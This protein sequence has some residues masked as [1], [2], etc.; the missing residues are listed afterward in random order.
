NPFYCGLM[1]SKMIPGQVIE[2]R[3]EP[4]VSKELFLMVH[5]IRQEGRVHGFVHEKENDNLP[6]K[7]FAKCDKCGTY[8]T[9]YLVKKKGLYY[10]KC[11]SKGC[12]VNRSAKAMHEMFRE[13]LRPFQI[14][15]EELE[16]VKLQ[17]EE[18]LATFFKSQ[19]DETKVLK[20]KLTEIKQKLEAIEERFVIGEIDRALYQKFRPKYEK[21]FHEIENELN[22]TGRYSSN[23][24]CKLL[25]FLNPRIDKGFKRTKKRGFYPK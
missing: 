11:P 6:L 15:E 9:G 10:Y 7:V 1:T 5:N 21:E 22:K 20:T 3:H 25:F 4:L 16:L 23:Q 12:N 2:G 19:I 17:I 24:S 14:G 8:L 18:H 13:M